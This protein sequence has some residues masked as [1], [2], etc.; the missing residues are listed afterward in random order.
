MSYDWVFALIGFLIM[1][2]MLAGIGINQPRG[3]SVKMWCYGYLAISIGFDLL[4]VLV[5]VNTSQYVWLTNLLLGLSAGA[6][7]GLGI[8]VAH[9]I[10]EEGEDSEDSGKAKEKSLFG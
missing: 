1:F 8:H 5:L 10:S 7:T 6:A 9:H 4:V 2:G 3:T